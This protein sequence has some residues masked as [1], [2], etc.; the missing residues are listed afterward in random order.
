LPV[1]ERPSPAALGVL[2]DAVPPQ[3]R[4]VAGVVTG[5]RQPVGWWGG[6][7]VADWADAVDLALLVTDRVGVTAAV[8][9][10]TGVMPW[11]PGRC[12]ALSVGGAL[13]GYAGELHPAV[14]DR[15]GLPKRSVAFEL[16]LTALDALADAE[17]V[18]AAPISVVPAAKEDLA[19]V[20]DA[21]TPARAVHD[22]I[23]AG[24]GDL[25][26]D[27]TLFDLYAGAQVG[28][29]KK[30]LAYSVRLR[31]RDHTLSADEVRQTREAIIAAAGAVGAHLRG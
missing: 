9:A 28:A 22:A 30:S 31:A 10:A 17:I 18:G 29:G 14:V 15:L 11:H 20:V 26:E 3:P 7:R 24:A 13:V 1:A 27:V 16:D 12:A 4:Y 2:A 6:G 21:D 19:F 25:L 5:D 8:Q 23:A